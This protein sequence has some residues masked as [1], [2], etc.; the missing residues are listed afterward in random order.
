MPPC[1]LT[2]STRSIMP[3]RTCLPKPA[4]GPDRSWIEPIVISLFDTPCVGCPCAA[5]DTASASSAAHPR[6]FAFI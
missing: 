4:I 2:S 6:V 1:S 3:S 5:V